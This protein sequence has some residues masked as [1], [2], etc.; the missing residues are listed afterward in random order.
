MTENSEYKESYS[1]LKILEFKFFFR[2][3]MFFSNTA[4]FKNWNYFIIWLGFIWINQAL[5]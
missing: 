1:N 5:F 2:K 4:I 3:K